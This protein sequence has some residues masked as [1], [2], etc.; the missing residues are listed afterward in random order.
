MLQ[1]NKF[2]ITEN[3]SEPHHKA[4]QVACQTGLV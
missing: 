1:F 4:L 2:A 3:V